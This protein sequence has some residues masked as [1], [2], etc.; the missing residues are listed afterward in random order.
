MSIF[1]LHVRKKAFE[2]RFGALLKQQREQLRRRRTSFRESG[3]SLSIRT[4][5]VATRD[6]PVQEKPSEPLNPENGEG[7]GISQEDKP[8]GDSQLMNG[9]ESPRILSTGNIR[10]PTSTTNPDHITF[11]PGTTFRTGENISRKRRSSFSFSGVG[12]SP[13]TTSFRRPELLSVDDRRPTR[14][15]SLSIYDSTIPWHR[16]FLTREV[17]GR[18]SQFHG[19]T[20]EEREQLG[21]VE[22][23]AITLLSWIVPAYFVAWQAL[24]AI[25]VG[26]WMAN[27]ARDVNEANGINPW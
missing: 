22:Y 7:K 17:T 14:Q 25:A 20:H 16:H 8:P 4:E 23:R 6:G 27:N 26:A 5:R 19:L 18:N 1:V 9:A 3:R 10:T 21:G 15:P 11:V 12:A 24:S 13:V 2:K